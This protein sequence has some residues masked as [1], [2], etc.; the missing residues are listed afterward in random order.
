MTQKV[1]G[2]G[3][4][5]HGYPKGYFSKME[6][7]RRASDRAL[8]KEIANLAKE[9]NESYR[10]EMRILKFQLRNGLE[11]Y[12]HST[13]NSVKDSVKNAIN[14]LSGIRKEYLAKKKEI[15]DPYCDI[16]PRR[17]HLMYDP[18]VWNRLGEGKN[19]LPLCQHGSLWSHSE[20]ETIYDVPLDGTYQFYIYDS[21]ERGLG[22]FNRI[23]CKRVEEKT[24]IPVVNPGAMPPIT[25]N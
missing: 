12:H 9:F 2:K 15:D 22:S 8:K 6:K 3:S 14:I 4:S 20:F 11:Y 24:E 1:R 25:A 19:Y 7:E 17:A 10:K 23:T 5:K 13:S 21:G 18:Y 16:V